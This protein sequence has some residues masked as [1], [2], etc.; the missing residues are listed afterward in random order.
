[1]ETVSLWPGLFSPY[2]LVCPHVKARAC[3]YTPHPTFPSPHPNS[4]PLPP[5]GPVPVQTSHPSGAQNWERDSCRSWMQAQVCSVREFSGCGVEGGA[6]G[7]RG[8]VHWALQILC[9]VGKG[10]V[11]ERPELSSLKGG[12]QAEA[13]ISWSALTCGIG[14][15]RGLLASRVFLLPTGVVRAGSDQGCLWLPLSSEINTASIPGHLQ[16]EPDL[17][18]EILSFP[19]LNVLWSANGIL[20]EK[21]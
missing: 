8:Y 13:P 6:W 11:R 5:L 4:S 3:V 15:L 21:A 7:P 2:S 20:K 19:C 1:M 12:I 16:P 9:P 17:T 10:T 14:L 18:S